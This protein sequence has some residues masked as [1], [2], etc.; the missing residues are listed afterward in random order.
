M[1]GLYI[2]IPFCKTICHYC[3]FV[4]VGI[5]KESLRLEYLDTLINELNQYQDYFHQIDTIYLGGG[6]PNTLTNEELIKLFEALKPIK[7]DEFSIEINPESYTDE[8]GAI[9]KQYGVNR[10]SIGAQTTNED[11][12]KFLNRKH[13]NSHVI[14]AVSSLKNMG[15]NNI[16]LDLIFAIPGQTINDVKKDIEFFINLEIPHL[17][18]YNLILEEKTYFH[19]LYNRNQFHEVDDLLSRQMYEEVI[20]K[21]TKLGYNHYEISNFSKPNYESKHNLKYWKYKDYIGIGLGSHGLLNG[22]RLYNERSFNKYLRKTLYKIEVL[23]KED[24]VTEELIM[25]LR[26]SSGVNVNKINA[27]YEF[28]L[29]QKF[30]KIKEMK[31]LKLLTEEDGYLKSTKEGIFLGNQVFQIFV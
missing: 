18:Y 1:L 27:K 21:L 30:P 4:K 31:E 20:D 14:N 26:L 28:N 15:I 16:N 19:Y 29:Y 17:S 24:Q 23:S 22:K 7:P 25:G 10:V 3:D 2:H 13:N 5:K 8:Q 11:L 6:T 12:L 9:F